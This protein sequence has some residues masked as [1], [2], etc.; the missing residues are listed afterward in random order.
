MCY[1]GFYPYRTETIHEIIQS[2]CAS[3]AAKEAGVV[4]TAS[5][6][7]AENYV[8]VVEPPM[9]AYQR[10]RGIPPIAATQSLFNLFQLQA[11]GTYVDT[12]QDEEGSS[13]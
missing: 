6:L 13:E 8:P 9:A 1:D 4:V 11:A 10:E 5:V 2:I 3:S 7:T 12:E